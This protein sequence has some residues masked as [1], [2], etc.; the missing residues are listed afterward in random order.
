M[1]KVDNRRST[2]LPVF[3]PCYKPNGR[4]IRF[5]LLQQQQQQQQSEHRPSAQ[6]YGANDLYQ[7]PDKISRDARKMS[8]DARRQKTKMLKRV[9]VVRWRSLNGDGR[10]RHSNNEES[11][12]EGRSQFYLINNNL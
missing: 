5:P 7:K 1:S 12:T 8:E 4:H 9:K 11:M 3:D 6:G 10:Q 2:C